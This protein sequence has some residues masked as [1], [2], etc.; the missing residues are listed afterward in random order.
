MDRQSL[1]VSGRSYSSEL[2]QPTRVWA[3][4]GSHLRTP[5]AAPIGGEQGCAV[6]SH[7]EDHSPDQFEMPG[8]LEETPA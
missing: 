4:M 5:Q 2:Q 6:S 3:V 8:H 1:L 7:P